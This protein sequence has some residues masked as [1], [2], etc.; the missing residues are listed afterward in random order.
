M[1]KLLITAPYAC[2]ALVV[3]AFSKLH[4][5]LH[6]YDFTNSARMW[7]ALVF[8][9]ILW[10]TIYGFGIPDQPSSSPITAAGV[11]MATSIGLVSVVQL[12]VGDALLPRF[13]VFSSG[14][15]LV[16]LLAALTTLTR[17]MVLKEQLV[18]R[19]LIV[20]S[21]EE[22][23]QLQLDLNMQPEK[24]AVV[25]ASME[26]QLSSMADAEALVDK[27][28]IGNVSVLVLSREAQKSASIVTEAATLHEAGVRVRSMTGFYEEWLG[29]LPLNE[30]ERTGLMFDIGELHRAAYSRVKRLLDLVMAIA[31]LP[32]FLISIPFVVLGDV[33]G[34]W[35]SIFFSQERVGQNGRLFKMYKFRTMRTSKNKDDDSRW[36][37]NSDKRV[38]MFGKVLRHT[39]LDE[40]PQ[41]LN[42][43]RGD[44]SFVGPRPEQ[45]RYVE[46]LELKIPF[47]GLRHIVRPGLTGWAQVKFHYG[48]SEHDASEKLQYEFYYMRH[49]TLRLDAQIFLRTIGSIVS[50][51]RR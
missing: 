33:I 21:S 48:A 28:I 25:V 49:Q 23:E 32:F 46:E 15:V 11:A 40:L 8:I 30:L 29:K 4:A 20:G 34:N 45:A 47:Y 41:I 10:L 43:I 26:T 27:A 51:E 31:L 16:L 24:P 1:R 37:A 6:G 18:D 14:I 17:H 42:I 2:A 44:L 12:F 19:I 36:T 7:W 5:V 9:G 13:V 38:T 3:A 50:G 35:G 39:H 22:I